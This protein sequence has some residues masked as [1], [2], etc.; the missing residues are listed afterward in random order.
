MAG[1]S[2]KI[3]LDDRR[4]NKVLDQLI[5]AGVSLAEP[6][7]EIGEQ[8]L[9]NTQDRFDAQESPDGVPWAPL[10][11]KYLKSKRKR[12]SRGAD[13][14]LVLDDHLHGERF[15]PTD[16]GSTQE[17]PAWMLF[18]TPTRFHLFRQENL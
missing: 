16:V 14:I 8:L 1:T 13:A 15:I 11:D 2:I 9:A 3:E 4:I 17:N 18:D 5:R 6:M 12:K 7:A 10:S